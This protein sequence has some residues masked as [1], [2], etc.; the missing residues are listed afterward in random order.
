LL[1]ILDPR[2]LRKSYG[3]AFLESLPQC[4]WVHDKEAIGPFFARSPENR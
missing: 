1:A 4:R 2:I 3:K